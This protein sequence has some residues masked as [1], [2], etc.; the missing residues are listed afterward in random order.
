M[1]RKSNVL[2]LIA[3]AVLSLVGLPRPAPAQGTFLFGAQGEPVCL[4]GAVIVDG[5]S[6]RVVSQMFEA[7]VK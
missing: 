6:Q 1:G 2:G 7:L 3:L 5:I 4:D